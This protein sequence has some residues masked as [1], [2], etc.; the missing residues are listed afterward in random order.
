MIILRWSTSHGK[1]R[2]INSSN[3][4][5]LPVPSS[6][7]PF[8]SPGCCFLLWGSWNWDFTWATTSYHDVLQKH[9]ELGDNNCRGD[10]SAK[11]L[12]KQREFLWTQRVP[13]QQNGTGEGKNFTKLLCFSA[14]LKTFFLCVCGGVEQRMLG[15]VNVNKIRKLPLKYMSFNLIK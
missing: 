3:L 8:N 14:F 10:E 11:T 12:H 6:P 7:T 2:E 13:W 15:T 5:N 1:E 9:Q 4:H